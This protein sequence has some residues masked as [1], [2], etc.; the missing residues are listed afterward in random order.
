MIEA[1]WLM[2][3]EMCQSSNRAD[4]CMSWFVEC[5]ESR[6]VSVENLGRDIDSCRQD[7]PLELIH[8]VEK[9]HQGV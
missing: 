7:F 8:E 5:V 6:F 4:E 1:L 3:Q 2:A 9:D